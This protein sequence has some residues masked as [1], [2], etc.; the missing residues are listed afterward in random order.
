MD[1]LAHQ[2][3]QLSDDHVDPPAERLDSHGLIHTYI[4]A[5]NS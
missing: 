5:G 4:V 3:A 1:V 2:Q